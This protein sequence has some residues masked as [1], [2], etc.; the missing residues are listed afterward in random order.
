MKKYLILVVLSLFFLSACGKKTAP[1]PSPTPA[2][3]L[4]EMEVQNRPE[5][6]L[7]PRADG[8]ELIL[9]INKISDIIS[10]IE[11]EITYLA[12]DTNLEIEKGASGIIDSSELSLSKVERKILLGTESCT[13]G[14]KYKYD[15][16]VSGGK[17]ILIFSLKNG[18][19]SMFETPFILRS[20]A[21]LKKTGSLLVWNEENFTYTPKNKLSGSHYFI[22][23]KNF[24][25][26]SY[27]VTSSGSL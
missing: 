2:P 8:H 12:T 17:L 23:H 19:I 18:Q 15:S 21:E 6:S 7:T 25:D 26:G 16:G 10:K 20:T 14:C 4:V 22:A 24:I 5:I 9:K 11:Y 3:K 1:A 13:N 27:L